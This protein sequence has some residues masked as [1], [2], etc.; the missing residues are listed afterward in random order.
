MSVYRPTKSRGHRAPA[1]GVAFY[2]LDGTLIDLNLVHATLYLFANLGEW[3]GRVSYLLGFAA[4]MPMLYLAERRDRHL[5]NVI[6]FERFKGVSRDRLETLGEEYCDRVLMKHLYPR[7][8]EMLEANRAVGL[9]PVLVTGSPDFVVAP[10]AARLNIT[11]FGANRLVYSRGRATG[12]LRAPVMAGDEKAQWCAQY[13]QANRLD[14][15]ACWGYADS[16]YDLP[17]LAA[18]GHPVAVNPDR[19]LASTARNRQWPIMRFVKAARGGVDF[20]AFETVNE[21]IGRSLNGAAGS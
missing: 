7:A 16:H 10:L 21:L 2:D 3:G 5:L 12:R 13:A 8:V 20:G 9:E 18:L 6:L 1:K 17:F 19:R 15:A 4:R 11:D 14:L